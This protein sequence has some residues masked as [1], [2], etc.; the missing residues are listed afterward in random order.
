MCISEISKLKD[1]K[2]IHLPAVLLI[3]SPQCPHCVDYHPVY[4]KISH[5]HHGIPF[6]S[7]NADNMVEEELEKLE[8]GG[9]PDVRFINK[10]GKI[11]RYRGDRNDEKKLMSSFEHFI[12]S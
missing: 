11:A 4:T 8:V 2:I 5:N 12:K 1:V 10:N 3:Y 6:I 7:M 9:I